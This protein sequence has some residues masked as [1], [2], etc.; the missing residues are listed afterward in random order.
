M[1]R[2]PTYKFLV[3]IFWFIFIGFVMTGDRL[4]AQNNS[5]DTIEPLEYKEKL[6]A[7]EKFA[8]GV[9]RDIPLYTSTS[10]KE[11]STNGKVE[12]FSFF[13]KIINI[14]FENTGKDSLTETFG[15]LQQDMAR[16][17]LRNVDCRENLAKLLSERLIYRVDSETPSNIP[18]A[19]KRFSNNDQISTINGVESDI[20][21]A[22]DNDIDLEKFFTYDSFFAMSY[23]MKKVDGV[24]KINSMEDGYKD[25]TRG[26]IVTNCSNCNSLDEGVTLGNFPILDI[27]IVNKSNDV[28]VARSVSILVDESQINGS[29]YIEFTSCHLFPGVILGLNQG[30]SKILNID[31]NFSLEMSEKEALKTIKSSARLPYTVTSTSA[32]NDNRFYFDFADYLKKDGYISSY[33]KRKNKGTFNHEE[34]MKYFYSF[35]YSRQKT[36]TNNVFASGIMKI[37]GTFEDQTIEKTVKVILAIPVYPAQLAIGDYTP[38]QAAAKVMLKSTGKNYQITIPVNVNLEPNKPQRFFVQIGAPR[39]SLHKFK[40]LINSLNGLLLS[41]SKFDIDI[42]APKLR[43]KITYTWDSQGWDEPARGMDD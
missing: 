34:S 19:M 11:L 4:L 14:S 41:E 13:K 42:F 30:E 38:S 1:K 16:L 27:M 37:T 15:I 8:L 31:F 17:L 43:Q 6:E 23:K 26:G 2:Q 32:S 39:S 25:F 21:L 7:I 28:R 22:S 35:N 12:C 40:I 24:Y 10:L 29:P 3:K 9:C 36:K 18:V 5:V 20:Q 33:K